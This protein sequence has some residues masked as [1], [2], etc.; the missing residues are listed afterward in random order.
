MPHWFQR[1]L[2][3]CFLTFLTLCFCCYIFGILLASIFVIH[4]S[5]S[6]SSSLFI[7]LAR[8]TGSATA[9]KIASDNQQYCLCHIYFYCLVLCLYDSAKFFIAPVIQSNKFT[10][11]PSG[12]GFGISVCLHMCLSWIRYGEEL[13]LVGVVGIEWGVWEPGG[14]GLGAGLYH[15]YSLSHIS[16]F[17]VCIFLLFLSAGLYYCFTLL[18]VLL[19][20]LNG[21]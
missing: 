19:I 5:K 4:Q 18:L 17:T 3:L 8:Y 10:H 21:Q 7:S 14:Y 12:W 20:S 1:L 16:P 15:L 11:G 2:H 9:Q 6:V 13:V